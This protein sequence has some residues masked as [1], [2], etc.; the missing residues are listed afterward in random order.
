MK[1]IKISLFIVFF[2]LFTFSQAQETIKS[3]WSTKKVNKWYTQYDWVTGVNFSPSTAINQLEFWQAETFDLETIDRELKWSA[4]LGFNMHRVFLHNLVWQQNSAQYLN[5]IEQ[6]LTT[7][8]KYGIKTMLVLFDDVWDPLPA[9]GTQREPI[10]G[11][12]N[13]GWVQAPGREYLEDGSKDA[14]LE[15]YVKGI[16]THFK[17]DNRVAI[18]D[19][20][21]EPGN[22]NSNSY[23]GTSVHKTE[24]NPND[25]DKHSLRLVSKTIKWA[26]EVNPSQP[27]TM[28]IW[29]G[30][31]DNWGTPEKLPDLDK[32][33]ILNSDVITFHAY[34]NKIEDVEKKI[35]VLQVYERP[36]ICSEYMARTNNN[37]FKDVMPLFKEKN[38][39]AINWGFVSGKTNTIYPWETWEK[40]YEKEPEIWFHDILRKDGSPFSKEEVDFI[41][42]LTL[43]ESR[44]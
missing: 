33:M 32:V 31:T 27:L 21:N 19:L 11:L 42:H 20:Y 16:L 23:G 10:K 3:K 6:F 5:R 14:L 29:R 18:W 30:E 13:S 15:S 37:L 39:G 35:N 26:R 9:L 17:N 40:A 43:S 25:K 12:H 34:D 41:K 8:D 28:G 7:S 36:I 44:E 4:D 22:P 1:S 2:S 24:L 38:V